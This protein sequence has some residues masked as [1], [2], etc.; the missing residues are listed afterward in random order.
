MTKKIK[1]TPGRKPLERVKPPPLLTGRQPAKI[2]MGIARLPAELVI[3]ARDAMNARG[4]TQT[5]FV[6]EAYKH[7]LSSECFCDPPAISKNDP[8]KCLNCGHYRREL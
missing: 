4:W 8:G 5:K 3:K 6:E 1:A 7:L 2:Q